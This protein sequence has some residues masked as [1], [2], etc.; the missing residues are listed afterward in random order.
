MAPPS[1]PLVIRPATPDDR[2]QLRRAII[3]LQE[4]E[5]RRH[6][7]RLPGEQIADAY[8][9]WLLA[10]AAAADGA[11][12]VA[13]SGTSFAGFIAGWIEESAHLAE[14]PDSNR[15]GYISDVCVM[16]A[17]RGRRIATQLLDGIEAY[18]RP[19]GVTRLRITTLA[20]N[21]SARASYEHAGFVPYEVLYEKLIADGVDA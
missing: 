5:R 7:T 17:S 20:V 12:L 13:E 14:T 16:P 8:L 9:D 3:E 10:R 19:A 11:V 6:P 1:S 4:Y 15:I 2:P 21:A 18:L